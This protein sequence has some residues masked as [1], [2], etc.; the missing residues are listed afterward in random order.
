M[1]RRTLFATGVTLAVLAALVG[2]PRAGAQPMNNACC[3]FTIA[4]N[5]TI[6]ANCFPF[7]VKTVW[8]GV[9]Q[10]NSIPGTGQ[11]Q[12]QINGCP[13]VPATLDAIT[14]NGTT[15][16]PGSP[17]NITLACGVCVFVHCT[18]DTNGC[19]IIHLSTCPP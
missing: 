13:P 6:P 10:T 18:Y 9:G 4:A 12:F 14:I 11:N 7:N 3:T 2:G 19:I 16:T 5:N 8:A 1:N 17:G 15:V